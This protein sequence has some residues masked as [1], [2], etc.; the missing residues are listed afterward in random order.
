MRV[1][2]E[3]R[4]S[5]GLKGRFCQ[6]RPTGLGQLS[7]KMSTLKGSFTVQ[8]V[9]R[10]FRAARCFGACPGLAAWADRTGPSGRKT[11]SCFGH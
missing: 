3:T 9:N 1:I 2:S 10:P 6:P 11:I 7:V 5:S 8:P 4:T